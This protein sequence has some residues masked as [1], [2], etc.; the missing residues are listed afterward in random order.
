MSR[1]LQLAPTGIPAMRP[2]RR[3]AV[4]YEPLLKEFSTARGYPLGV[5]GT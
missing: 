1:A 2:K 5:N 3:L 4:T